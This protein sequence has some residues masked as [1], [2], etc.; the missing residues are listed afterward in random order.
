MGSIIRDAIVL[1][2][3]ENKLFAEEQ[4]GFVPKRNCATQLIESLEAWGE[5]LEEGES[6]DIIFTDFAKAFDSVP[7]LRLAVKLESYGINGKLLEWIKSFLNNRRRVDGVY[8]DWAY[9]KSGVP[10]GSVLGPILFVLF[11]NDMPKVVTNICKLF[12]D[13]AKVSGKATNSSTIQDDLD[14]LTEWSI[15]WQL[16]FNYKKCKCLHIGRNNPM[17]QYSMHGRILDE[18]ECEKDLGV[19]IDAELK[20]HKQTSSAV[21]KANRMLGV[22]KGTFKVKNEKN[23]PLL[24]MSLVRP[25][26]EYANVVWGPHY[27][28]DQKAVE[29]VPRIATK[30]IPNIKDLS[31]KE[32]LR[33]L[34]LPSLQHRRKRGDMIQTYKVIT[35]KVNLDKHSLFKF[36]NLNTR[37]HPHKIFKEH[38]KTFF[39]SHQFSYRVVNDWNCLPS[40][41]VETKSVISFKNLL[42]KHW[43]Q[44]K[45][46]SPFDT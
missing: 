33:Q 7:H 39:K 37:G 35:G 44:Y 41:I 11:I 22:I 12:A 13:D 32:R 27:I 19:E 28:L 10:Q 23:F 15:K 5:M 45:F 9:V 20:F 3:E 2:M 16:P 17:K 43:Y 8:S 26:L 46:D 18:V 30:I 1:H 4:H 36:Q 21:K 40:H 25:H 34:N 6:V 38:A 31:Y 42:D 14:N 24:Y 29:N